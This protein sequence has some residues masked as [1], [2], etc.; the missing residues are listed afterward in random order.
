MPSLAVQS[1]A[2]ARSQLSDL[3]HVM[4]YTFVKTFFEALYHFSFLRGLFGVSSR[5]FET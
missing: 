5:R 3:D 1:L 4:I 2:L